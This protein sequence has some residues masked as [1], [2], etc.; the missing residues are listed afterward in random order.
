MAAPLLGPDGFICRRADARAVIRP[1][2][3]D[4][5]VSDMVAHL[6]VDGTFIAPLEKA[7]EEIPPAV[8]T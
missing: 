5:R 4:P 2:L 3:T 7:R 6:S 1:V 8:L